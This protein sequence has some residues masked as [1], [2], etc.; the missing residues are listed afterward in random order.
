M[1]EARAVRPRERG[2][3]RARSLWTVV[4]WILPC[5]SPIPPR[6]DGVPRA[7]GRS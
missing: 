2:R 4:R 6:G 1:L 5:P 7:W 3:P